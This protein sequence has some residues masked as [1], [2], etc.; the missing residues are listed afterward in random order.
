MPN[1]LSILIFKIFCYIPYTTFHIL[2]CTPLSLCTPENKEVGKSVNITE[3]CRP[4]NY[5]QGHLSPK[6]L[7]FILVCVFIFSLLTFSQKCLTKVHSTYCG[8]L[9][10]ETNDLVLK[11]FERGESNVLLCQ[12]S[13]C[14][15]PKTQQAF[16]KISCLQENW[17]Y[18]V[19]LILFRT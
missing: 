15:Y 11:Y 12:I 14:G 5:T 16:R 19:P 2:L 1:L 10:K 13:E 7:V 8:I 17:E 6:P 4:R 18:Q 9:S 3:S